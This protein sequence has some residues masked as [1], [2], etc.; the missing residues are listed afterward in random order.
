MFT[1]QGMRGN[2]ELI[3]EK[4]RQE[5]IEEVLEKFKE[6]DRKYYQTGEDFQTVR[7]LYKELERLGADIETVI[8]ID[9]HIRDEVFWLSPVKAMYHS[10]MNMDDGYINHIAIIQEVNG[11]HNHFL[12]D[13]DKG[14]GAAGTGPFTTLEEAKQDVIAHYPDAV[15]QEVAE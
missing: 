12:Y 1:L 13:E 11:F 5:A 2:V 8:D 3:T 7:D 14:K 10:T 6:A 15:E 9:L 4:I